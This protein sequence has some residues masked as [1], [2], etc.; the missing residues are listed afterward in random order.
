MMRCV[1]LS[2]RSVLTMCAVTVGLTGCGASGS[3]KVSPVQDVERISYGD[4]PSQWV[5][6][7]RP[8]SASRGTVIA[9]H[10]GFWRAAYAA[11]LAAPLAADLAE[12]GWTAINVE[13]RR[14]G[15]GGG[16]PETFDDIHAAINLAEQGG[17]LV[18]LG[19]S[20]GGH[21]ATWAAARQRF[22]RWS[23]GVEV[24]HVVAQ[25]GVLDLETAHRQGLGGTA[26]QDLLGEV[27]DVV[28]DQTDPLRQVPLSTPVW[29]VHAEDD[30][31][32]PIE[33]SRT[34]VHAA[35]EAGGVAELTLV[36]GGHFGVIDPA[37]TAWNSIIGLLDLLGK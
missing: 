17:P 33:Q 37:S 6:I 35:L 3:G 31:Q 10:G 9:I 1:H 15:N 20:A 32:V 19:H 29:C 7:H 36:E 5:D 24:T 22:G 21:L 18:T 14:V 23:G 16:F 11:D 2:R 8:D 34:Y 26:V 28:L 30:Q 25:A 4:D 27:T 13:Y 12:R